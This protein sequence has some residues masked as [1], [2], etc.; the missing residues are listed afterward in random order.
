LVELSPTGSS[1]G[2]ASLAF[3]SDRG[4]RLR[5]TSSATGLTIDGACPS[6]EL[7]HV[8]LAD[9]ALVVA[10]LGPRG[11]DKLYQAALHRA[12]ELEDAA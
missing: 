2:L 7:P 6:R 8:V 4:E 5:I 11:S 9:E 1:A 12:V 3:E 10:A